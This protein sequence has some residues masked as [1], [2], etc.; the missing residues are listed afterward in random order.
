MITNKEI[1]TV[2]EKLPANKS[3]RPDSL[4]DEFP[5]TLKEDLRPILLTFLQKI[6]RWRE[7]FQT[8]F[9]KHY[10]DIRSRQGDHNKRKL[11]SSI[12]D[13]HDAKVSSKILTNL[14]QKCIR[15][16]IHHEEVRFIPGMQDGLKSTN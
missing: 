12:L 8:H 3:Q 13:E 6:L 7:T 11:Q 9:M 1:K 16:I 2:V 15:I 10:P 4:T 5:K 14:I